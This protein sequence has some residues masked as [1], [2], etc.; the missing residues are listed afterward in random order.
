ML[1]VAGSLMTETDKLGLRVLTN[2]E[3]ERRIRRRIAELRQ[4]RFAGIEALS[5]KPLPSKPGASPM[6]G[7]NGFDGAAAQQ[8]DGEIDPRET[9]AI[10]TELT[11]MSGRWQLLR[12]FLYSML[13]VRPSLA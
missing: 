1:S 13:K 11:M 6:L 12:R 8:G 5:K 3:E 7:Q 2:W 9:D 10:V 4:Y